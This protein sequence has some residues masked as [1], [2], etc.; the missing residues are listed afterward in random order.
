MEV[1]ATGARAVC[2]PYAGG[3]ESEQ[4]LRCGLLARRGAIEV[5]GQAE[6]SAVAVAVAVER[7]LNAPEH[8]RA[9][10]NMDGAQRSAVLLK[11]AAGK[12]FDAQN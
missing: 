1:L 10:V 6:V 9:V 8:D 4:T 12:R 7:A 2:L 3:L 11:E 5:V